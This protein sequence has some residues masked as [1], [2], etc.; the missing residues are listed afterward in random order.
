MPVPG[1]AAQEVARDSPAAM[2]L[3][4]RLAEA[5]FGCG[6]FLLSNNSYSETDGAEDAIRRAFG[7]ARCWRI[8]PNWSRRDWLDEVKAIIDAAASCAGVNYDSGRGVPRIAFIYVRA[9]AAAWTRYRQ[10]WAYFR[11]CD[12]SHATLYELTVGPLDGSVADRSMDD[13]LGQMLDQL[14]VGDQWLIR[15]LFW[16]G[17]SQARV[18]A[19]LHISQQC[20]SR[21]K[22]RVLRQLRRLLNGRSE[23]FSRF[24]TLCWPV[25]DSLEL[26]PAVDLL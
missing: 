18:A 23:V 10:E 11:R 22:L 2:E 4:Q 19:T 25:L 9:V 8:P 15:Q 12:L 16:N 21:R 13:F 6:Q 3:A 24:L 17:A 5:M 14:P 7:R 20:V 26:L 1:L